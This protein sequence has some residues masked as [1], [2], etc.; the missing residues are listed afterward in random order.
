[1]V[2]ERIV[3][4]VSEC[5]GCKLTDVAPDLIDDLKRLVAEQGDGWEESRVKIFKRSFRSCGRKDCG[6]KIGLKQNLSARCSIII[7]G[8]NGRQCPSVSFDEPVDRAGWR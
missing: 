3:N 2:E 4:L 8:K 7:A 6:Q 5:G 1:M